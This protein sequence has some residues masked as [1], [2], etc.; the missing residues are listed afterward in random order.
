MENLF[1]YLNTTQRILFRSVVA[2]QFADPRVSGRPKEIC[3]QISGWAHDLHTT[4]Q[5]LSCAL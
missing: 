2:Q 4:T 1:I 3:T 5:L